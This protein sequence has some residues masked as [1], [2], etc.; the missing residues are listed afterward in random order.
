M[1]WTIIKKE[2]LGSLLSYKFSIIV[3]LSTLLILVSLF[4]MYQDYCL[5]LENYEILLSEAEDKANVVVIRPTP[6][7]IYAKGLE[8]NLCRSYEVSA[9]D[10]NVS[11]K[12]QSVNKVFQLFT[13]PDLL[14]IVKV[15]LSLCAILFA[16]DIVSGCA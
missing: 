1:L 4:V 7:S 9:S 13:T 6:L 16:F 11:S 10:I 3:T 15:I 2:I 5:V 8:A 14:Y 12:Q